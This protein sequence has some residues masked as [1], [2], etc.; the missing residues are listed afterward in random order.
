VRVRFVCP[1][2]FAAA[3]AL[4]LLLPAPIARADSPD[5]TA[6]V[7]PELIQEAQRKASL[8]N[9][10]YVN[11]DVDHARQ[12]EAID[13]GQ[14]SVGALVE[15]GTLTLTRDTQ[16]AFAYVQPYRE[17]DD[18]AH[19]NYCGAGA[20]TELLSHWDPSLPQTIDI[21]QLGDEMGLDPNGG[22]WVKDMVPTINN[23][24]NQYLGQTV[25]WYHYDKATSLADFRYM[26]DIDIRQNGVPLI[27]GVMTGGLPGWGS[28]NVGHIIAVYGYTRSPDGTEYVEYCD[29]A[30]PSAG[31]AG[32]ILNQLDLASFWQAAGPECAVDW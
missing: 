1:L 27:T 4:M 14:V 2:V 23:H 18:Y 6:G 19:R 10:L 25:D 13:L 3:L 26:L 31:Y 9:L 17:P 24:L 32:M 5:D 29:T 28:S 30:A 15:R 12:G 8:Q 22:L 11:P 20:V 16:A 7:S 21:D